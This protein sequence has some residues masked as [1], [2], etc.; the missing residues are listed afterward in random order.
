MERDASLDDFLDSDS[1]DDGGTGGDPQSDEAGDVSAESSDGPAPVASEL[2][3]HAP[4]S[5]EREDPEADSEATDPA[6]A[7]E[8][9]ETSTVEPARST[10]R[11]DP[12][13]AVCDACG[14]SVTRRWREESEERA[15]TFVCVECKSW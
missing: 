6:D 12:E 7:E 11:W 8:S 2:D 15:E 10:G 3:E 5:T 9:P 4:E 14:A 1:G 13:G